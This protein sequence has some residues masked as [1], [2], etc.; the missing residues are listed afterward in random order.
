VYY[1]NYYLLSANIH[2]SSWRVLIIFRLT[3]RMSS[4]ISILHT[5]YIIHGMHGFCRYNVI[6]KRKVYNR[7]VGRKIWCINVNYYIILRK[8]LV[9]VSVWTFI[10][11]NNNTRCWINNR[12]SESFALCREGWEIVRPRLI[13]WKRIIVKK[14]ILYYIIYYRGRYSA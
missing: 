13:R 11:Y 9:I 4:I 12:V 3:N 5:I 6:F 8:K 14:N 10:Y 2:S 1:T 7:F